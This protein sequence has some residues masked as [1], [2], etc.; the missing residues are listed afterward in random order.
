M[1]QSQVQDPSQ[2]LV[3]CSDIQSAFSKY[4]WSVCYAL[5]NA[6]HFLRSFHSFSRYRQVAH[7]SSLSVVIRHG[8]DSVVSSTKSVRRTRPPQPQIVSRVRA[9]SGQAVLSVF[10]LV[11]LPSFPFRR[12]SQNLLLLSSRIFLFRRGYCHPQGFL[13]EWAKDI[14]KPKK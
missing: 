4:V 2:S 6:K 11:C 1:R 14:A 10:A 3:I 9:R 7:F 5:A 8:P 12:L 13:D